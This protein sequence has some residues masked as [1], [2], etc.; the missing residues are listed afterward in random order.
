MRGRKGLADGKPF[1][2]P[3]NDYHS[4]N[5][6]VFSFFWN[7]LFFGSP[8]VTELELLPSKSLHLLAS[9]KSWEAIALA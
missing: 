9:V 5:Q 6:P 8:L 2:P 7:N 3:Q 1:S 4:L